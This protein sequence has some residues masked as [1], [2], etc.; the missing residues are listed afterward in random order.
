MTVRGSSTIKSSSSDAYA[1]LV[2]KVKKTL[3]EGQQRIEQ[4]RVR[5]Y[6]EA[7]RLIHAHILKYE[8]ARRGQETVKRLAQDLG[9]SDTVLHRC[10]KFVQKYPDPRKVATWPLFSWSHYRTLIAIPDDKKRLRLEKA[11]FQKGWSVDELAVRLKEERLQGGTQSAASPAGS[12]VNR[13]P[14]VPL[15][16]TLYT[17][18]LVERPNL[19]ASGDSGLLVDLGFGNYFEVEPRLL[20]GFAKNQ[21]VESRPREDGY[22]FYKTDRTVKDLFT[23]AAYVEKVVDGD[24]LKVRLDLGFNVWT[25][26]VLRLR[27]LDC[28]EVGTP[29]GDE[30]RSFARSHL[31]EAQL[32]IVRSSRS[33][34]YDRYLAD[35]F[36]PKDGEPDPETDVYLNNLLLE[37]GLAVRV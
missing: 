20:T 18:K 13:K 4:E 16:G 9:V 36:I 29:E 15:R 23:Y 14:L 31:K 7:G 2:L 19:A 28:P 22:K 24:T 1:A 34:K 3:V 6:W 8:R 32:I 37:K 35:V 33:D 21:I 27:D 12:S 17:Y 26:Q 25:R 10:V 11:V 30:A 5:T